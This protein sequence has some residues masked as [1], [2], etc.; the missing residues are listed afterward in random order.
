MCKGCLFGATFLF[1]YFKKYIFFLWKISYYRIFVMIRLIGGNSGLLSVFRVRV[2]MFF[3]Y[4]YC[5]NI[6]VLMRRDLGWVET[7]SFT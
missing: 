7:G 2:I 6:S 4:I 3:D 1:F 5:K